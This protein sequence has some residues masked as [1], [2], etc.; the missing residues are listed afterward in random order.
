M[1]G[2]RLRNTFATLW[3]RFAPISKV[4]L[5]FFVEI[6]RS[7]SAGF[8]RNTWKS[9]ENVRVSMSNGTTKILPLTSIDI[10]S[11]GRHGC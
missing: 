2:Y 6:V 3:C 10:L 4:G 8:G 7:P 9:I 11:G 1:R 5:K